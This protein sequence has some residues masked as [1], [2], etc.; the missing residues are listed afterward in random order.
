MTQR[1]GG[2][3]QGATQQA[4]AV[5]AKVLLM[6]NQVC[7]FREQLQLTGVHSGLQAGV[8]SLPGFS[9]PRPSLH[10]VLQTWHPSCMW[11]SSCYSTPSCVRRRLR[12][13]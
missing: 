12:H 4:S 1:G 6:Q 8:Q 9:A 5:A 11:H 10:L 2:C 7:V 13:A 3:R